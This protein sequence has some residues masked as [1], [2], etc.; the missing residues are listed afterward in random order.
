MDVLLLALMGIV[1]LV[2]VVLLYTDR[3]ARERH[4]LKCLALYAQM[5]EIRIPGPEL[6]AAD[7]S[8]VDF[9]AEQ[10][11]LQMPHSHVWSSQPID[12][13]QT[14]QTY[15]CQVPYCARVHTVMR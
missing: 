2:Q 11:P 3:Q 4:H 1:L 5:L 12:A 15:K 9:T 14:S 10:P 6:R 13:D 8:E 7:L